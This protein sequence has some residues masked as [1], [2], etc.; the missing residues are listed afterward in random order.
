MQ[1]TSR[2]RFI[3]AGMARSGTTVTHQA[4]Q[5]HPNVMS[6]MD[7]IKA[8]PFFS[9]GYAVF[10]VSGTND[11][12]RDHGYGLLIDA[13]SMIPCRL[14]GEHLMGFGGTEQHP[15]G[16]ILANGLKMAIGSPLEAQLFADAMTRFASLQQVHVILVER[17]DLVAQCASLMRAMRSGRWHS[18]F[19][20]DPTVPDP[21]ASFAI[22]EDEFRDYCQQAA[23]VKEAFAR[24]SSGR[25]VLRISYEDDIVARGVESFGSLFAFLGLPFVEPSWVASTKVAP[26]LERFITNTK[27][28]YRI[29]AEQGFQL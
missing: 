9:K 21:D 16:E 24:V 1:P 26:P 8:D 22:P 29:L 6:A 18:F 5:G 11:W 25:R 7:E 27:Q 15:K 12:E 17:R 3:I 20:T 2:A 4:L 14:R 10:T 23:A 19:Q 13:L 28:L